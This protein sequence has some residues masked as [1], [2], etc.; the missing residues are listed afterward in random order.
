M[1]LYAAGSSCMFASDHCISDHC[2]QQPRI[3]TASSATNASY[4]LRT[5]Q[6]DAHDSGRRRKVPP[7]AL[8]PRIVA[9]AG[10][11]YS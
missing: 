2:T 8:V 6:T 5:W 10:K 7:I 3:R 11:T 4:G 1:P 9:K